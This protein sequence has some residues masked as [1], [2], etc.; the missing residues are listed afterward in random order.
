MA[1]RLRRLEEE[2]IREPGWLAAAPKTEEGPSPLS[3]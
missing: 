3:S 2:H 1:A